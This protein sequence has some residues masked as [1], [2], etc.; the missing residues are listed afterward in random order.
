MK[1]KIIFKRPGKEPEIMEVNAKYKCDV[2][3]LIANADIIE[4]S[5]LIPMENG[6]V[7]MML[8]DEDGHPKGLP[9]NFYIA[10]PNGYYRLQMI[11]GDCII[12]KFKPNSIY[13][14]DYDFQLESLTKEEIEYTMKWFTS[15][16]QQR[17]MND[18]KAMYPTMADYLTPKVV[19][20]K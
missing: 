15:D 2:K 9:F 8:V 20:F 11:V 12:T 4:H 18:F 16:A 14:D 3:H 7:L 17:M 6:T 19:S 1:K 5:P 10:S 13:E